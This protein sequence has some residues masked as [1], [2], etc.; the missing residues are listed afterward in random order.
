M[1]RRERRPD[2][3]K[4]CA[5]LSGYDAT[6][7]A[8]HHPPEGT[9]ATAKFSITSGVIPVGCMPLLCGGFGVFRR[10][11]YPLNTCVAIT[12]LA[13]YSSRLRSFLKSP[14]RASINDINFA[15]HGRPSSSGN[16]QSSPASR[17]AIKVETCRKY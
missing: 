3:E 17:T 6:S 12:Q 5:R 16:F 8:R 14:K 4:S 2:A 1:Q 10:Q 13:L 7:N 15:G 9:A 11:G